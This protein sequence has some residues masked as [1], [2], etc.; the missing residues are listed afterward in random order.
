MKK[1]VLLYI[2]YDK[3]TPEL[4]QAWFAWFKRHEARFV[5]GG[6]PLGPG[7]EISKS[8]IQDLPH[9][10]S[11]TSGY[12]I[13]NAK[14]MDEAVKIAQDCPYITAMRVYEAMSM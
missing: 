6:N 10:R 3:P 14:D 13:I 8:G 1:F 7:K 9:D 4:M 12:G 2:G 11:A 5:D